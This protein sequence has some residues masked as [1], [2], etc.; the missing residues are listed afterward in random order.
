MENRLDAVTEELK[1]ADPMNRL[2]LTQEQIDLKQALQRT[3]RPEVD[4]SKLERDFIRSA[5]P[6]AERKKLSYR[7][8]RSVGVPTEVLK[9]AGIKRS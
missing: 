6:Y 7:A 4:L 5:A 8:F 1:D 9:K 3:R 2:H